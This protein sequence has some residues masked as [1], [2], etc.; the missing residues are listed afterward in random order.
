[1]LLEVA[2][3]DTIPTEHCADYP[4]APRTDVKSVI[5]AP[6]TSSPKELRVGIES[7]VHAAGTSTMAEGVHDGIA[8]VLTGASLGESEDADEVFV[9]RTRGSGCKVAFTACDRTRTWCTET[10]I[11]WERSAEL[12]PT[13]NSGCEAG[14]VPKLRFS[15]DD[16]GLRVDVGDGATAETLLFPFGGRAGGTAK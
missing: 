4:N 2:I 16:S 7:L 9:F 5:V 13:R 12:D 11:A 6:A 10:T 14:D 1:M 3:V 15:R 8:E